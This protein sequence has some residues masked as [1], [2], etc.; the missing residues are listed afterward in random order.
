MKRISNLIVSYIF[1]ISLSTCTSQK[2]TNVSKTINTE[3]ILQEKFTSLYSKYKAG[4]ISI[5][6]IEQ[7]I[8][9]NGKTK[10]RITYSENNNDSDESFLWET[11]YMPIL[12]Q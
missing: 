2:W 7:T 11:I 5:S 6:K 12:N 1:I 4:E 10:Y 8:D 3:K 9:N